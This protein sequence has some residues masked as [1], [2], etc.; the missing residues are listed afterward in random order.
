MKRNLAFVITGLGILLAGTLAFTDLKAEST[1]TP[2]LTETTSASDTLPA[3]GHLSIEEGKT[4]ST[5]EMLQAAVEDEYLAREEYRQAIEKFGTGPFVNIIE[6][7]ERHITWVTE[8]YTARNMR[9]PADEAKQYVQLPATALEAAQAG[10]E[11]EIANIA[12]YDYFLAQTLPDDLRTV[13]TH[14]RD[15]SQNHLAAFQQFVENG[16]SGGGGRHG[17]GRW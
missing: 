1:P 17:G 12:M 15:A 13:F 10:V 14:L 5:E 3:Y 9:V 7:E 11:A 8:L 4:Y 16:G 6:S 2:S